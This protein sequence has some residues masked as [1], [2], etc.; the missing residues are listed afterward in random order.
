MKRLI[1]LISTKGKTAEQISKETW[2]A[3]QN[4]EQV[5]SKVEPTA[6]TSTTLFNVRE[7][8]KKTGESFNILKEVTPV[9]PGQFD[10]F[11]NVQEQ[12]VFVIGMLIK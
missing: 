8:D 11:G 6:P 3:Y 1:S 7:T 9:A 2:G 10:I 12:E 4:Y 5:K